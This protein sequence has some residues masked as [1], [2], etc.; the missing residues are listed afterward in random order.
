MF[1]GSIPPTGS[2]VPLARDLALVEEGA[3][4]DNWFEILERRDLWDNISEV[5]Y[6]LSPPCKEGSLMYGSAGLIPL[7]LPWLFLFENN[8]SAASG[9][10]IDAPSPPRLYRL[11]RSRYY[12]L[13]WVLLI[14]S[15]FSSRL[16]LR[17]GPIRLFGVICY[18][19][20]GPGAILRVRFLKVL[21]ALLLVSLWRGSMSIPPGTIPPWCVTFLP[22]C[23]LLASVGAYERLERPSAALS[24]IWCF[25]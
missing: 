14:A 16:I 11:S 13:S 4:L 18:A 20:A 5:N 21:P 23:K 12:L 15:S 17:D 2:I 9:S 1:D 22:C 19:L 7:I 24:A 25:L 10:L 8:S 6:P 3:L